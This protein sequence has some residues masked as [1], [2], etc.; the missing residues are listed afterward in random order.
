[1]I[2]WNEDKKLTKYNDWAKKNWLLLIVLALCIIVLIYT[3]AMINSAVNEANNQ[4][5]YYVKNLS[6]LS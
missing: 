3:P 4:C 2:D 6:Y 1:M 5:L